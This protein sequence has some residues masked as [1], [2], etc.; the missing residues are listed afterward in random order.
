MP[1]TLLLAPTRFAELPKALTIELKRAR[2][3]FLSTP[4]K[5]V[6]DL[7]IQ[8]GGSIINVVGIIC[9]LLVGIRL[10]DLQKWGGGLKC[11]TV[12]SALPID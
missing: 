9:I 2:K 6:E 3:L 8:G 12:P 4:V 10:N 1:T 5:P 7:K 11:P